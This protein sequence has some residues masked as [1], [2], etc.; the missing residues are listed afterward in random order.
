M[1]NLKFLIA[2]AVIALC[3]SLLSGRSL[4]APTT[5]PTVL[6]IGNFDNG[7]DG[8]GGAV[9]QDTSGGKVGKAC[10]MLKNEKPGGWVE[11]GKALPSDLMYDF[12]EVHF[13]V[14][15]TT[16][17][18][19]AVRLTDATGQQF[20]HRLSFTND[21]QWQQVKIK[22]LAAS[23]ESWGG[24][25][26]KKW[27]APCKAIDLILEGGNNDISIDGIEAVLADQ[28]IP[29]LAA[30]AAALAKA[31]KVMLGDFE[32]DTDGF[33]GTIVQ[34][35][36]VAKVGKASGRIDNPGEKWVECGKALDL[37]RD[38]AELHFWVRSTNAKNIAVR[39][40][41]STGQ[42]F[43]HRPA[44][45]ANGEWQLI[46]MNEFAPAMESWGGAND[47]KWHGPA[48]KLDLIVESKQSSVWVDGIE[49][50]LVAE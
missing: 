37:P 12:T 34:D 25:G 30:K 50:L 47:K 24:A 49:V 10:I 39:L 22:D 2:I 43:Q 40:T 6:S 14:K 44:F 11:G 21:G 20:Q 26:D 15:S 32:N 1:T 35:T 41:D 29:E 4:A 13:W 9:Q 45:A 48:K 7:T 3:F 31:Q 18:I 38:I 28:P 27:H 36:T 23:M 46:K 5:A 8:F 33:T 42:A 19:I 16:A 17:K